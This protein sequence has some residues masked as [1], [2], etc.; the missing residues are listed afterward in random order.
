MKNNY[1]KAIT[2]LVVAV[3]AI[4]L[5][6][7]G[8]KAPDGI[9]R[10]LSTVTCIAAYLWMGFE[11]WFWKWPIFKWFVKRP[12]LDGTW[13]AEIISNWQR[14]DGTTV[15]PIEGYVVIRQTLLDLSLRL[16]TR[17]SSSHLLGT[18]VV[19]SSDGLYCV[20]GVYQNHP[21]FPE[22]NHSTIHFGGLW[23]QVIETPV[24]KLEG[25]YWTD[26]STAG[27]LI[28]GDRRKIKFQDFDSAQSY[29]RGN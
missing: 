18:E 8:Q 22:R 6:V 13:R 23:L 4:V 12:V 3:W 26:R 5:F 15:P 17:E 21:K 1:V 19:C 27:T 25:H 9:L 16:M 28:L 11:L 14:C 10:P 2:Y 20:S 7:S 29:F 24:Q